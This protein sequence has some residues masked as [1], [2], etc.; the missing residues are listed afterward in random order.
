MALNLKLLYTESVG[1]GRSNF[2][3][4][5]KKG[6]SGCPLKIEAIYKAMYQI[7]KR[8]VL[9]PSMFLY[10]ALCKKNV[11]RGRIQNKKALGSG[12][13]QNKRASGQITVEY[14]LLAVVLIVIFQVATK[15]LRDSNYLEHF[16][17]APNQIFV[18]LIEN[19]NWEP[20]TFQ[21]K[22]HHP[23]YL[24]RHYSSEGEPL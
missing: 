5:R 21:S 16:Q 23:N 9:S 1:S 8:A 7:T 4:S 3:D 18:N 11:W 13:A 10:R 14:I 15:T 20:N 17:K 6:V 24:N 12:A 19:G 2:P 22:K